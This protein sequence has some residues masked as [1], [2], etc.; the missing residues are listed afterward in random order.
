MLNVDF[1]GELLS[2]NRNRFIIV[3]RHQQVSVLVARSCTLITSFD[4]NIPA[5]VAVKME[6]NTCKQLL[7]D[8][9]EV[10]LI[11]RE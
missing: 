6:T 11:V 2:F 9:T 3:S 1:F 5:D 4:D 7:N 8:I 10:H